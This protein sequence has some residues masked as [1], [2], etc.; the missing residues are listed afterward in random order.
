MLFMVLSVL[1]VGTVHKYGMDSMRALI[2]L[3]EAHNEV[4][5][6]HNGKLYHATITANVAAILRLGFLPTRNGVWGDA[7]AEPRTYF[8]QDSTDCYLVACE[9]ICIHGAEEVSVIEI[10]VSKIYPPPTFHTDPDWYGDASEITTSA[11]YTNSSILP[12][13]I[14]GVVATYS[15]DDFD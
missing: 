8:T 11:I 4:V 3:I 9:M 2:N 1:S 10:D 13:S 12:S 5:E 14:T 15:R 7:Y 6:L